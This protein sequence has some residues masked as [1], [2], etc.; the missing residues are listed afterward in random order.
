M[1]KARSLRPKVLLA[2]S[3]EGNRALSGR[4]KRLGMEPILVDTVE[5]GSPED[6]K[7]VDSELRR[8][9]R[10]DWIVLTSARGADAFAGRLRKLG[11][12][13]ADAPP[14]IAA[15]G[16]M[17]AARLRGERLPVAFVPG[18]FT[19]SALGATLPAR[20]GKKVLLLR[21]DRAGT[22]ME[23]ILKKRGFS[24]KSLPVYT[25]RTLRSR[26][27]ADG[28]GQVRVVIFGSSSEVEGLVGR[29]SPADL[30]R[31]KSAAVAACIGPVTAESARRAGFRSVAAPEPHTFD[32]LLMEVRRLAVR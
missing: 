4:L 3:A 1:S 14:M 25:T 10:Y 15:V 23:D 9:R 7:E 20:F 26:V 31:L 27:E 8:L 6:W 29:L 12:R 24:T 17:T 2:R 16:E 30:R 19:T 28:I 32:A 18:E 21:A 13:I 5:F 11:L 22:E